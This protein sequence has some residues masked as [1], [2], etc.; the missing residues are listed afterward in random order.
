MPRFSC[1][2][3]NKSKCEVPEIGVLERRKVILWCVEY[4]NLLTNALKL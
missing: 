3:I 4:V 1:L 2:K